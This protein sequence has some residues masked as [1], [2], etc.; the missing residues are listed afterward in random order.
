MWR[1]VMATAEVV[2]IGG[3]VNGTSTAYHLANAGMKDV[4]LVERGHLGS[5]AS[6]KSG[7]LV[8]MHYTNPY[9][10]KLAYESLKVFNNWSEII[11]GDCGFQKIGF[12]QVVAPEFEAQLRQ[13]IEDQ[14]RIGIDA[15]VIRASDLNALEPEA[16]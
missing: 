11:G 16:D 15:Q 7:A 4:V 1:N 2:V 9:E 10:S 8:R 5:G 14:Q 6:G 13:N 3:G 12:F